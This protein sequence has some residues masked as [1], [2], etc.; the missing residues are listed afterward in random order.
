MSR[1]QDDPRDPAAEYRALARSI[2]GPGP[3]PWEQPLAQLLAAAARGQGHLPQ[4]AILPPEAQ[5]P[6]HLIACLDGQAM[7]P[8]LAAAW[9]SLRTALT[10]AHTSD[11]R[12]SYDDDVLRA[13]LD[14]IL[15]AERQADGLDNA[16]QRLAVAA[17]VDAPI[18][19]LTG[20]PG[21]GKTT[22]A[23]ALLALRARLDPQL[24][25]TDLL[26]AAP[27][28]KAANRLR[29]A[30]GTAAGR[31]QLRPRERELLAAVLP[32]TL[33]RALEWSPLP[34]EQGG[35]FRRHAGRPLDQCLVLVDEAS[36]AD[37]VLMAQL[38]Q[39]LRPGASL[40][41]LG[42]SDQLASVE[43]GGVLAELVRRGAAGA[44]P[45]ERAQMLARRC[46]CSP[47]EAAQRWRA[48][49]P[50]PARQGTA[51]TGLAL[52][53][54]S[55]WRARSAPW[56]LELAALVRPG[57]GG[58]AVQVEACCRRHAGPERLLLLER[59]AELRA[60]CRNA[61]QRLLTLTANWHARQLPDEVSLRAAL[62]DFQLLVATNRQVEAYNALG[63]ALANGPGRR[64]DPA[65]LPHG[66][67]L[68]IEANQPEL[69]LANGDLGLALGDGPGSPARLALL[70]GQAQPIPL[71]R[72]P[73]HRP[74]F[75][76]TIH[77]SQGSEWRALAI[78]L[79]EAAAAEELISRNLLY[80]AITRSAGALALYAPPGALA[81]AVG[82]DG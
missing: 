61:W 52:G 26:L 72:L 4:T 51:L 20:G 53:L 5:P 28:G 7:L 71:A 80:T 46:G 41:L 30:L 69:D 58:D 63:L 59:A 68:I 48:A 15:P 79:P 33:H 21:T 25:A 76:L 29:Q 60:L 2:I 37:L 40:I 16:E 3:S 45:K 13:A 81:Q 23:A 10:A 65:L 44:L 12:R 31:L 9:R 6:A 78:A 34:P 56:I 75:A 38:V 35:P 36:M 32:H 1:R 17:L 62:D 24:Q 11:Q 42:D 67:P 49:L 73:R 39:A 82:Q 70:P 66:C 77:K 14:D 22:T 50:E 54:R 47:N 57:S 19:V 18:G 74:A 55:S 27:T 8:R 64:P 43:A